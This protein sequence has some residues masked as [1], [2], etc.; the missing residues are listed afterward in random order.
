MA[1][2]KLS[3]EYIAGYLDGEGYFG[4]K[5]NGRRIIVGNTFPYVLKSLKK[6]Y[7]GG[8]YKIK[9]TKRKTHRKFY[10]WQLTNK[11]TISNF[12]IE[13]IPFLVEKKQQAIIL[14]KACKAG[15]GVISN[16]KLKIYSNKLSEL[17]RK[18]YICN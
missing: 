6:Q 10:Y 16:K 2:T 15:R 1:L 8:F 12:L 17:K 14:L 4:I 9:T 11:L 18:V 3:A 5:G 7:G 13:I